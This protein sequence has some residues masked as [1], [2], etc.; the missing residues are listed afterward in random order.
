M[1]P[2]KQQRRI[3]RHL[4]VKK[5]VFGTKAVPRIVIFKSNRCIYASLVVD[6]EIPNRVLTTVSCLSKE[7]RGKKQEN[8]KGYNIEGAREVGFLLAKKSLELGVE[9]VVFDRSGY[10]YTGRVKV[11]AD[12]ARKGGLK[13]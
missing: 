7:I 9:K 8:V 12:A 1:I 4:R 13:F 10:R 6:E 2:T 3:K 5:K 11:L